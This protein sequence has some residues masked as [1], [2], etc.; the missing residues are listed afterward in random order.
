[1]PNGSNAKVAG[2]EYKVTLAKQYCSTM[3]KTD[4]Y[5]TMPQNYF[6]LRVMANWAVRDIQPY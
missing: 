1:M 4:S 5:A 2:S 6:A 3:R